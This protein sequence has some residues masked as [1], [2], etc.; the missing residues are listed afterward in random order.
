MF[1][2]G[3]CMRH[4]YSPTNRLD[5]RRMAKMSVV[6]R[7]S[8]FAPSRQI[9]PPLPVGALPGFSYGDGFR[10]AQWWSAVAGAFDGVKEVVAKGTGE[11]WKAVNSRVAATYRD[12]S[13]VGL[14]LGAP[15]VG[16]P[17][18]T[19]FVPRASRN[20]SALRPFEG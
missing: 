12:M 19:N 11:A 18:S 10:C 13:L 14:H 7:H 6:N 17:A 4:V 2:L 9:Q 8:L 5:N 20:P 1:A 15:D 16:G 3:T